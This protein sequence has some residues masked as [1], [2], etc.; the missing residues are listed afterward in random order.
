M[1]AGAAAAGD[2]EPMLA[3]SG[4][5]GASGTPTSKSAPPTAAARADEGAEAGSALAAQQRRGTDE[6]GCSSEASSMLHVAVPQEDPISSCQAVSMHG[7]KS[8]AAPATGPPQQPPQQQQLPPQQPPMSVGPCELQHPCYTHGLLERPYARQLSWAA[9]AWVVTGQF[10]YPAVAE[11]RPRLLQESACYSEA[12][13]ELQRLLP[14]LLQRVHSDD[15]DA[16]TALEGQAV[17][18]AA[19]Y[20]G[21]SDSGD[22]MESSSNHAHCTSCIPAATAS[23]SSSSS[24]RSC[25]HASPI[26]DYRARRQACD[27]AGGITAAAAAASAAAAGS[28]AATPVVPAAAASSPT[29][30]AGA[31]VHAPQAGPAGH[32]WRV[33]LP[34]LGGLLASGP[35]TMVLLGFR[36][37]A[38]R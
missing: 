16:A 22:V 12:V 21:S 19:H 27:S 13:A 26:E 23:S 28:S 5:T 30:V 6:P 4:A 36:L 15:D 9:A 24:T 17:L 34:C 25:Q 8:G 31:G 29:A 32:R 11:Q 7:P 2:A 35:L 14:K 20:G 18:G 38:G 37:T 1:P 3:A 10:P 33:H